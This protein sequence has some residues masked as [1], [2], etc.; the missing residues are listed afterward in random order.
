MK[1]ISFIAIALAAVLT[2]MPSCTANSGSSGTAGKILGDYGQ[3][4]VGLALDMF[5][6][7]NHQDTVSQTVYYD[8]LDSML[9]ALQAKK[10]DFFF[11][12]RSVAEYICRKNDKIQIVEFH[13]QNS[14]AKYEDILLQLTMGVPSDK[15]DL[16]ETLNSTIDSLKADGTIESLRKTY[17]D[18]LSDG[19]EPQA[20]EIPKIDGAETIRVVVTGDLPPFDYTSADGV[21]AGFNTALL[22]EISKKANVNIELVTSDAASR[23]AMLTSGKADVIFW[24]RTITVYDDDA[25]LISNTELP[26]GISSTNTFFEDDSVVITLKK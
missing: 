5:G 4:D 24:I 13:K 17:I 3:V 20:V 1:K 14:N 2:L 15:T 21:P 7:A 18:N 10:I 23:A 16:L 6:G 22:A 11:M 9:M 8:N 12:P 25:V 19:S 26:E